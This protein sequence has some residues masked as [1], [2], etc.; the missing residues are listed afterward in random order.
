M[1]RTY[2]LEEARA[3]AEQLNIDFTT[4][5]F[6]LAQ[7]RSGLEVEAEHGA[8][9][10]E[11]NVTNDDPVITGKIALAHLHELP[12]YYTRLGK[13]ESE[14]EATPSADSAPPSFEGSG[15]RTLT[16]KRLIGPAVLLL[17]V[18]G[19]IFGRLLRRRRSKSS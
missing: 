18:I 12:D 13:M 17:G 10:P 6:D 11:T 8:A 2:S 19:V 15:G 4:S 3:I 14:A 16:G 7:F 5:G 9:D 1:K